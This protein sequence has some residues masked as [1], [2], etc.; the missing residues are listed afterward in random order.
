M[1]SPIPVY[2]HL[3]WRKPDHQMAWITG[4]ESGCAGRPIDYATQP[5]YTPEHRAAHQAGFAI[6]ERVRREVRPQDSIPI[7]QA[8]SCVKGLQF[9]LSRIC[10]IG[11]P[12]ER[13][14]WQQTAPEKYELMRDHIDKV[15]GVAQEIETMLGR[16]FHAD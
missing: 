6:G 12:E 4:C 5:W 15:H 7:I 10:S 9:G 1:T 14:K 11:T 3:L 16:C 13:L 8:V 2:R